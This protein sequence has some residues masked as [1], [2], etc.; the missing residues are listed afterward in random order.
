MSTPSSS[1]LAT[2]LAAAKAGDSAALGQ[3]LQALEP[4]LKK[5]ARVPADLWPLEADDIVQDALV[6]VVR[7]FHTFHGE[8][9]AAF[10]A[11]VR[12]VVRHTRYDAV[13]AHRAA[14]RRGRHQAEH[15]ELRPEDT[16]DSRAVDPAQRAALREIT[17]WLEPHLWPLSDRDKFL[18]VWWLAGYRIGQLARAWDASRAAIRH[19]LRRIAVLVWE[20]CQ[21]TATE[22]RV[23]G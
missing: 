15:A 14:K 11:W 5:M 13:K 8:T 4:A 18:L 6:R 23:A 22:R 16:V 20:A 12:E 19:R 9:P 10:R 3:S 21:P 2:L 7:D 1:Q 17:R